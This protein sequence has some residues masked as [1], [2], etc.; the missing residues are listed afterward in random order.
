MIVRRAYLQTDDGRTMNTL[1][2]DRPDLKV[3]VYLTLKDY[4]PEGLWKVISL[5]DK[6]HEAA[7][8]EWHK[9]WSNNI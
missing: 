5:S 1:L 9:K 7:D 2:N 6:T 8:F 3:G 4:K